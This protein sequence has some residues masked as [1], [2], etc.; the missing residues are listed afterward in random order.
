MSKQILRDSL[1]VR[2]LLEVNPSDLKDDVIAINRVTKVVKGGKNLSFSALVVV[3]DNHGH[4]GFGMG[5]AREVPMAIKKGIEQAKKNLIKL[6]LKGTSIPHQVLG[7]YGSAQVLLKPAAE[8]TGVIAGGP[9]RKVMQVA[10]IHNVLTK[11]LGTS[12]PHNVVKATFAALLSLKDIAQ[13]A[14]TR[15]KTVDEI[16]GRYPKVAVAYTQ[17]ATI[18]TDA[19]HELKEFRASVGAQW[20]F[21]SDPGRTVQKDLD[22]QEYTDPEHDP[23]IPHTLVLKPGLVVHTVYNGYW[24]WGRPSVNDL[25][26]DLRAATSEIRPDWDLSTPGLREAWAAGDRSPF[27]GWDRRSGEPPA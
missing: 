13:V 22:I 12:N 18:S 26:R 6:N 17:M 5:K 21:L 23:M 8:G 27:H 2:R 14:E 25:W 3:G 24:F 19:D 1:A 15:S 20:P 16:R 11:S 9:V 7:S 4:A 10:G